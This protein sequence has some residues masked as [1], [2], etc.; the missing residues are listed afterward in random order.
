MMGRGK[1]F[2]LINLIVSGILWTLGILML[3][4][5]LLGLWV[6]WNLSGYFLLLFIPMSL[7]SNILSIVFSYRNKLFLFSNIVFMFIS[8]IITVF[9]IL[10]S[11]TWFW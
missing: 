7:I 11:A 4:F 9:S 1:I 10:V 5:N 8:V 6:P 2:T 3:L